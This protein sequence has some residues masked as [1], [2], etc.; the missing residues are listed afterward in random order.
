MVMQTE[1][2]TN[3]DAEMLLRDLEGKARIAMSVSLSD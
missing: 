3:R 2:V 1:N